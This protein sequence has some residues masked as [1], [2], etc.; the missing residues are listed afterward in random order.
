MQTAECCCTRVSQRA[1][2]A[3][4]CLVPDMGNVLKEMGISS[5]EIPDDNS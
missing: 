5:Y 3:D 4:P 1:V 2:N